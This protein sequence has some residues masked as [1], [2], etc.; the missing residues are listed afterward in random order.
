M[1]SG[2][3][4]DVEQLLKEARGGNIV[5]VGQ[6]LERYRAYLTLLARVQIGRRLQ[7]KVDPADLVQDTFLH[8]YRDFGRFQGADERTL[9]S[10]LRHILAGKLAH[11]VRRYCTAQSRDIN[12]EQTLERELNSS[13][14]LLER[15]LAAPGS[16]PS[17]QVS[18][19]EQA[20][21]LAEALDKLP[22]DYRE[23]ILLRQV[24]GLAFQDVAARM[25]RSEDSVQK[26]WVRALDR[27]RQ[28][29]EGSS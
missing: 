25:Q 22:E 29:L 13:S 26:L 15:G 18:R 4:S 11:L 3:G 2:T 12:L 19:R 27:L 5:A 7:G 1:A 23:V 24:E 6:L 9:M 17:E 28:A 20:Q 16:S 21:L 8:A 14:D 10:W